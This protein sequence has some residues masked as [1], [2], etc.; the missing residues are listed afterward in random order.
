M[1]LKE[2]MTKDDKVLVLIYTKTYNLQ[3]LQAVR[4]TTT[5]PRLLTVATT[6]KVN[7]DA[8]HQY[9][10]DYNNNNNDRLTAFDP[11]QPG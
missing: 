5:T 7:S 6:I 10:N 3:D 11:G 2:R 9:L 4:T 8:H 1:N